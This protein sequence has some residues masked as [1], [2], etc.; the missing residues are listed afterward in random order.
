LHSTQQRSADR[1]VGIGISA[2]ADRLD[3]RNLD[4]T[5]SRQMP[6]R[7]LESDQDPALLFGGRIRP[8]T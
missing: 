6:K 2:R 4:R 5:S 1:C 3:Q 8:L 7:I